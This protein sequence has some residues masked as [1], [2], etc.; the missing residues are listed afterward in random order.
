MRTRR[1]HIQRPL[2]GSLIC[3]I[4]CGCANTATPPDVILITIDTLRA[5]RVGCYGYSEALTPTMDRLAAEGRRYAH[6]VSPVPIT[7]P[8]HA[9]LFTGQ[10]PLRHGVRNNLTYR[11][12]PEIPTLAEAM[13]TRGYQ[14]AAFV[15]AFPVDSRFGLD[16]GF[17][18]YD[19][20]FSG[21][22]LKM[23]DVQERA[24]PDVV[25]SALAWLRQQPKETPV[26]M[27]LHFFEPHVPYTP[28]SQLAVR[29][30]DSPYDGEVAAADAALELL[31][32]QWPRSRSRLTLVTSDHGEGLGEHGEDT[33]SL[34]LFEST[35]RVPLIVHWPGEVAAGSVVQTP[36]GL[37]DLAP[38]ILAWVGGDPTTQLQADGTVLAING[39]TKPRELYSETLYGYEAFGWSPSFSLR[40]GQHK[41]FR[42]ARSRA[43]DLTTD[44]DEETDLITRA[45][46]AAP[47][48][49]QL[50]SLVRAANNGSSDRS[51]RQPSVQEAEA[52][53]ALGYVQGAPPRVDDTL[54]QATHKRPDP[55]E[56][57]GER[58]RV[59]RAMK[60][61]RQR[62]HDEAL[63]LLR[64]VLAANEENGFAR[65]LLAACL[66]DAGDSQGAIAMY[67]VEVRRQPTGVEP[68]IALARL[69]QAAGDT[70]E[71]SQSFAFILE[72]DP[73]DVNVF[74][75][76][77]R[78]LSA[79]GSLPEATSFTR[80]RLTRGEDDKTRSLLHVAMGWLCLQAGTLDECQQ[81]LDAAE[82]LDP[83][84]QLHQLK[85]RYF[86]AR[87]Q[88]ALLLAYL[89]PMPAALANDPLSLALLGLAHEHNGDATRAMYL[90]RESLGRSETVALAHSRLAWI[91]A[92]QNDAADQARA[93][94]A[95]SLDLQPGEADYHDVYL[96]VLERLGLM[97]DAAGHAQQARARFPDHEGLKQ[98]TERY[99]RR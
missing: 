42:S 58:K 97:D 95:R 51:S 38:T 54:L 2:L 23:F 43:Y 57:L 11:L 99:A 83:D 25:E 75:E 96:E 34:F 86:R 65:S 31:L 21:S 27:W 64:E 39:T 60:L 47:L 22:E 55:T 41:V 48:L 4:V 8:A 79:A 36:V 19:D 73:P 76:C 28:P 6:C 80:L 29:F 98:R 63:S 66:R 91:L 16:R 94:A 1:L 26:L 30:A 78:F 24:A 35:L 90:Y 89:Q 88:W 33:H 10:L 15:G 20:S 68:R 3:M 53:A 77:V 70:E 46:W 37:I 82:R 7:L 92:T 17:A 56:Q 52:L 9:S 32:A 44:P 13:R 87:G 59:R 40:A 14:C 67:E 5:D 61:I 71:A 74:L 49:S 72:L 84:A 93:H 50:D 18:P 45:T 81:N 62:R 85:A 69:Q 12:P